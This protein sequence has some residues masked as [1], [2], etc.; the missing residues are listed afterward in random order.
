[1]PDNKKSMS[2]SV[3]WQLRGKTSFGG[4]TPPPPPSPHTQLATDILSPSDALLH[5]Q[6][7]LGKAIFDKYMRQFFGPHT[8]LSPHLTGGGLAGLTV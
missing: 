4:I 8:L 1:M 6:L 5:I 7:I 2:M 3:R